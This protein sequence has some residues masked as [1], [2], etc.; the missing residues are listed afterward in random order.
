[1]PQRSLK[2]GPLP[3]RTPVKL[4]IACEPNLHADLSDYAQVHSG[5]YGKQVSVSE[6][7]PSMLKTLI[8]SDAGFKR[9]RRDLKSISASDGDI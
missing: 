9:A 8:E 5:T 7:I 4:S 2:V 1:M 3:D 6:L